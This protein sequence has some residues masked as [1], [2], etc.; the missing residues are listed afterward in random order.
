[1][2]LEPKRGRLKVAVAVAGW[3]CGSG[4]NT[5]SVVAGNVAVAVGSWQ[6]ALAVADCRMQLDPRNEGV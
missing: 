3:Q 2:Q 6:L 1:V 4:S 5:G